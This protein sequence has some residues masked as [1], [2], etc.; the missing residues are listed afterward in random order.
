MK[1][2]HVLVMLA[3]AL[4]YRISSQLI[5]KDLTVL[6]SD[7]LFEDASFAEAV[8]VY[9]WIKSNSLPAGCVSPW[10]VVPGGG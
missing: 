3:V 7:A 5:Q 10:V 9:S 2:W 6:G 8:T 4:S 1:G